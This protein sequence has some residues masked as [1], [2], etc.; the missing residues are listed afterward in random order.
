MAGQLAS[1]P[2]LFV[3]IFCFKKLFQQSD[4]IVGIEDRETG[5][6]VDQLRMSA[7]DAHA[8]CVECTKPGHPFHLSANQRADAGF[9]FARRLV[10]EGD[11]ENLS[12]PRAA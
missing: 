7:Q 4:L 6:E 9:H 3:N 1:G 5:G 11:G 8:D 2:A 10:G 12:R